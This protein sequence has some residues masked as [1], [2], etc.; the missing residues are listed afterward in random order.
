M[1]DTP[2]PKRKRA[3]FTRTAKPLFGVLRIKDGNGGYLSFTS[4]DVELMV[5]RDSAKL[6]EAAV[7]NG[8]NGTLIKITLPTATKAAPTA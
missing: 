4:D 7:G 1:V 3:A 8:L 2:A 5:E 6:L